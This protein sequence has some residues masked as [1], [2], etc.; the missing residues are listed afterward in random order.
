MDTQTESPEEE[1]WH[2]LPRYIIGAAVGV[3]VFVGL[4]ETARWLNGGAFAQGD[5]SGSASVIAQNSIGS[6]TNN[7]GIVTQGQSGGTNVIVAKPPPR[8]IDNEFRDFI[9]QHF[10]E[11]SKEMVP[12]VLVGDD[13]PERTHF[14]SEIADFLR[15]DGYKV[16]D[17]RYFIAVGQTPM[18]VV[19]DQYTDAKSVMIKVGVNNRPQ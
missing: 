15:S 8:E 10:P 1:G 3:L 17:T 2:W 19:I 5:V 13:E 18:G 14:A 4:P 7:Q 11:K 16:G 12:M 9:R 6:I